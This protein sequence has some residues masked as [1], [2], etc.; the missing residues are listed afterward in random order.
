MKPALTLGNRIPSKP[1]AAR[2]GF[3]DFTDLSRSVPLGERTLRAYARRGV[4][5]SIILPGGCWRLFDPSATR[6][7]LLNSKTGAST[8]TRTS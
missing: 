4:F 8:R 5:P 1:N 3:C 6:A 2:P 7:A